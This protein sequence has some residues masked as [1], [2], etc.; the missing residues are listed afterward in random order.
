MANTQYKK[1]KTPE[2]WNAYSDAM[3]LTNANQIMN[4]KYRYDKAAIWLEE[5]VLEKQAELDAVKSAIK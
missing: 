1:P 3:V 4:D 5:I 2:D